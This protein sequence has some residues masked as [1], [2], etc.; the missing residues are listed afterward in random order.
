MTPIFALG[1]KSTMAAFALRQR[2]RC[3]R[4]GACRARRGQTCR[5][6]SACGPAVGSAPCDGIG[7]GLICG[8]SDGL[9]KSASGE[10]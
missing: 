3:V 9:P 1:E 6:R 2:L 7:R 5:P 8:L 4:S 10:G